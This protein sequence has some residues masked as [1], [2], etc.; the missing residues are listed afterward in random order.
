MEKERNRFKTD[1]KTC[2]K[3][4]GNSKGYVSKVFEFTNT[5][6]VIV[7]VARNLSRSWYVQP[8]IED[9]GVRSENE[10]LV[11]WPNI[12]FI[13]WWGDNELIYELKTSTPFIMIIER[14]QKKQIPQ[15]LK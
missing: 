8:D 14:G 15:H 12:V 1:S 10:I 4:L 6:E 5:V 2:D 13:L 7:E 9:F 11:I 3:T